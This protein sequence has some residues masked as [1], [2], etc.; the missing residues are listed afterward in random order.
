MKEGVIEGEE[1]TG[2]D[3]ERDEFFFW[4]DGEGRRGEDTK[5]GRGNGVKTNTCGYR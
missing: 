3:Y 2:C 5:R 1:E 4:G